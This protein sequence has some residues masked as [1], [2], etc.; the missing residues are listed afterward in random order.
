M[1]RT[2][3]IYVLAQGLPNTTHTL[4]ILPNGDGDIAVKAIT[5]YAPPL[6]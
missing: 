3:F 5:V 6:K 1:K 2:R 4:E